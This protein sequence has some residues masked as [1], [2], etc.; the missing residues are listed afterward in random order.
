MQQLHAVG[1]KPMQR[2][3]RK[4]IMCMIKLVV[5]PDMPCMWRGAVMQAKLAPPPPPSSSQAA[6]LLRAVRPPPAASV[7]PFATMG[8]DGELHTHL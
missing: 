8:Q 3:Q 1:A 7:D 6:D 4:T 2:V 5:G